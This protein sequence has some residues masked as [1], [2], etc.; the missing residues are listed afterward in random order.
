MAFCDAQSGFD[1]EPDNTN[2]VY[3]VFKGDLQQ[4]TLFLCTNCPQVHTTPQR[5]VELILHQNTDDLQNISCELE[6]EARYGMFCPDASA[7]AKTWPCALHTGNRVNNNVTQ[8]GRK[9]K[10]NL[11]L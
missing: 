8:T 1:S 7:K 11:H 10:G 4:T 2:N 5:K 3:L 9:Q 6:A